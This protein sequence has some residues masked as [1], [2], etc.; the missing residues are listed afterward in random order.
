MTYFDGEFLQNL[1][2]QFQVDWLVLSEYGGEFHYY[3]LHYATGEVAR[4]YILS[5]GI[6]RYFLDPD[7]NFDESHTSFVDLS[8][9]DNHLF[10]KSSPRATEERDLS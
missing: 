2:Y 5:D 3:E 8:K 9:F 6:F 7:N 1:Y 4:L 10:E